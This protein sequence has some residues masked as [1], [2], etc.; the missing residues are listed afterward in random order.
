MIEEVIMSN[1]ESWKISTD[2]SHVNV[3]EQPDTVQVQS[4]SLT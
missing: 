4:G 1:V 3:E 2:A